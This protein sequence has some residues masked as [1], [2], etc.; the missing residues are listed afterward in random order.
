MRLGFI[1]CELAI[2]AVLYDLLRM[3]GHPRTLIVAYAWH[4]LAIWEAANSGHVDTLT[5]MLIMVAVWLLAHERSSSGAIVVALAALSKP[6]AV[7]LLPAFWRPWDW[8]LPFLV[9]ASAVI[10]YL[11]FLAAGVNVVGFLPLY[12]QEE[13]FQAGSGFWLVRIVRFAVGDLPALLAAYVVIAIGVLGWISLRI[14]RRT[15]NTKPQQ[16]VR[17]AFVLLTAGLFFISPNYAWYY[18]ALVPFIPLGGGRPAWAITLGA[19]LLNVSWPDPDTRF[20]I[21]KS[22]MNAIFIV[23]I[24]REAV[25]SRTPAETEAKQG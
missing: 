13:G 22:L 12:L 3:F 9:V 1:G 15:D 16:R 11:P 23:T 21:W 19:I 4:P 24:L 25:A 20:L 5:T 14:L 17:D 2:V 10:C 18:L 7:V 6:Y 8:R